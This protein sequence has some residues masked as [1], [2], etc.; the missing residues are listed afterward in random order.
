MIDL[1]KNQQKKGV[2]KGH[3]KHYLAL[4]KVTKVAPLI[5]RVFD[6]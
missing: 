3:P 4:L 2:K 6:I 5:C 1:E